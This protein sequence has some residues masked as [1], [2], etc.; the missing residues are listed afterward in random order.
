M[1]FLEYFISTLVTC[2]RLNLNN[3]FQESPSSLRCCRLQEG[4]ISHLPLHYWPLAVWRSV[5]LLEN[6]EIDSN[7]LKYNDSVLTPTLLLANSIL[8][9][10]TIAMVLYE[11]IDFII[12]A[13]NFEEP[14]GEIYIS[15][16]AIK[17]H[18]I[19]QT[20]Y[21]SEYYCLIFFYL[22]HFGVH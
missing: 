9:P 20:S 17:I 8:N 11:T 19:L 3:S 15:W 16:N 22:I 7:L 10:N 12:F 21:E 14:F 4:I 6:G 1:N 18:R 13:K 5:F 2:A